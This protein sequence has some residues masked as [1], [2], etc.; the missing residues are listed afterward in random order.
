MFNALVRKLFGLRR[1]LFPRQQPGKSPQPARPGDP[2]LAADPWLLALFGELG[3]R[4]QPGDSGESGLQLLRRTGRARFNPMRVWLHPEGR[5]VLAD[6]EVRAADEAGL[7]RA[8]ALLEARVTP[9]L[10]GLGL[11]QQ[12]EA[13]EEWAGRVLTRRYQGRCDDAGRAAAAV[14]FV[15]EESE[16]QLDLAAE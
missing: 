8:R 14:R 9:R 12:G 2:R 1:R 4:Y 11:L 16:Q 15:C 6:Y 7:V 10:A 3:E 13:V 5:A